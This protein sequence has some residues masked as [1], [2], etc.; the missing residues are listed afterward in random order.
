MSLEQHGAAPLEVT[1]ALGGGAARGLAHIGVIRVLE[2]H[3]V[4]VR[5]VAGTS[6]GAIVGGLHCAGRLDAYEAYMRGLDARGFLRLLDPVVKQAG[7]LGGARVTRQ[8]SEMVGDADVA[9]PPVPFTAV[10][11]DLH[12][13]A[14]VRLR[15]GSLVDAMRASW[16]IPGVFT[17]VRLDGRWLVDGGVS[18]PVPVGAARELAPELPVIAVNLNNTALAFRG[19]L[20]D[21]PVAD[22]SARE[23]SRMERLF[24]RLR[25]MRAPGSPNGDRAP[26]M[27]TSVSDSV[28]HLE[29]K[30]TSFQLA[31][32]PPELLLEPAVF[33][34]GLFDFH[35]AAPLIEAGAECAR[36]AVRD[37]RLSALA[38]RVRRG[39]LPLRSPPAPR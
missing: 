16:A 32:D 9:G 20:E 13:G 34:V 22:E 37:G 33:G 2:A 31:A 28:T 5:G 26:G 21:P 18:M 15:S 3:G 11:T 17:P 39:E 38:A 7:L 12:T 8:L 19:S 29:H 4:A 30:I 14:E 35:R 6:I 36:N 24:Q 27:V 23:L 1:L 25:G 10:A